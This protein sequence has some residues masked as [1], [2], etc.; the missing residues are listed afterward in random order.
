MSS[1]FDYNKINFLDGQWCH[2]PL[3][4]ALGR[5]SRQISE[6]KALLVYRTS[7]KTGRT[8]QRNPVLKNE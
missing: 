8:T 1:K 4:L 2:A 5:Q 6:F 3:I 7:S